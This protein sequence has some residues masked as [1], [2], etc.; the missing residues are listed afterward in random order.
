MYK[1]GIYFLLKLN[2]I[3]H[4]DFFAKKKPSCF[5]QE[6]FFKKFKNYTFISTSTPAGNSNFIKAST[7]LGLA[8]KISIN[9][10]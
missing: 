10:L 8:E 1:K 4:L 9:L 6:G 7:V 2:L 3:L 5:L